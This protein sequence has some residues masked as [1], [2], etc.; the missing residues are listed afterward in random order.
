MPCYQP[1]E[2]KKTLAKN[3]EQPAAAWISAQP[4]DDG[5]RGGG[6]WRRG[7]G[8]WV[9]A[10]QRGAVAHGGTVGRGRR[11]EARS[12]MG[13]AAAVARADAVGEA[14]RGGYRG[15]EARVE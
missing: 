11:E 4:D 3:H 14:S 9:K 8:R 10:V 13:G 7:E 5:G 15:G 6:S 2:S 1:H 12:G